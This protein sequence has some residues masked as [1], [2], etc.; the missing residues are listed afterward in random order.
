M[1]YHNPR[2]N[3][4]PFNS[5]K[6]YENWRKELEAWTRLTKEEQKDWASLIAFGCLSPEDPSG[7]RDKVF[8]ID[9]NEELGQEA[10][11]AAAGQAARPAVPPDPL[12]GYNRLM[13]FLDSEFT[14]DNL[15]DMCEHIRAF[16]K[17]TK[18]KKFKMTE[19]T[20]G[21]KFDFGN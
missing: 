12:A 7:I 3:P 18:K 19:E 1:N 20:W 13:T 4:P 21:R 16:I 6:S 2:K 10:V 11:A 9:L 8:Q 17:M 14:K 15:T 5:N